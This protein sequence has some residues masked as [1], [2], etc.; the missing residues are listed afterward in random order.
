MVK[1]KSYWFYM[2]LPGLVA[3]LLLSA[4]CGQATENTRFRS[5]QFH[6]TVTLPTGWAAAEGPANLARP[7]TGLVAFNSWGKT[8]FRAKEVTTETSTRYSPE[9]VL[10]QIPAGGAYVVLV[11]LSGG[12]VMPAEQYGPEYEPQDL[13][14]LWSETNCREGQGATRIEFFKWGRFLS[15]E[16]YCDPDGSDE[17]ASA[18]N[19]LLSSWRFDQT[20]IGDV[21][22]AITAAR[23]LL[24][25]AIRPA[26]FGLS[27]G[28]RQSSEQED[29][30]VRITRAEIQGETVVVTFMYRWDEPLLDSGSESDACPPERCHWWKLEARPSGNVVLIEEGGAAWPPDVETNQPTPTPTP[31]VRVTP[32]IAAGLTIEEY[33]LVAAAV[34]TPDRIEFLEYVSDDIL[35]RRKEVRESIQRCIPGVD[36]D[37]PPLI[38]NEHTHTVQV[39]DMYHYNLLQDGAVVYSHTITGFHPVEFPVHA[40]L[41]WQGHWV[42]EIADQV[43]VD[44]DNLNERLG[45]DKIFNWRLLH[46]WPLYFFEQDGRGCISYGDRTMQPT[47]DEVRHN[48]CCEPA[49]FNVRNYPDLVAFYARKGDTWFYVE[50]G[51]YDE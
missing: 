12:P 40:L 2:V 28:V 49:L 31:S 38:I 42:L 16:I 25:P 26:R 29:D 39:G 13:G 24:P 20:P 46:G 23:R 35:A 33:P 8:G 19:A 36:S 15:L 14:G 17:T 44:G 22:W 48:L 50:M 41:E 47:Y 43:I 51:V 3:A 18:V 1:K 21:G 4:G 9:S 5:D 6:L 10:E 7:F 11:H 37:C 32:G 34:A 27:P 30:V 45:Y